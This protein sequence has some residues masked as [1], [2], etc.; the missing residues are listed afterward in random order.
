MTAKNIW[1][2][3]GLYKLHLGWASAGNFLLQFFAIKSLS[4][5]GQK[6]YKALQHKAFLHTLGTCQEMETESVKHNPQFPSLRN[7]NQEQ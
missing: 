1:Q 5:Q 4:S 3:I 6:S 2:L 7:P